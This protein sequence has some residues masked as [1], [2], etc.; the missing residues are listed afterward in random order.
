MGCGGAAVE[1]PSVYLDAGPWLEANPGAT[2]QACLGDG[3]CR[4]LTPGA[5]QVSATGGI[6]AQSSYSLSVTGELT[7]SPI[8]T[9]TEDVDIPVTTT[10]AACGP[11]RS[12]TRKMSLNRSGQLVTP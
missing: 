1:P 12:Q 6:G 8:L 4:T 7:G 2:A 9:V 11:S 5:Q 10:Q 3:E